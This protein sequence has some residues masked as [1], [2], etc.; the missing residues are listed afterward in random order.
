[1]AKKIFQS[2][3]TKMR[4][5]NFSPEQK[6]KISSSD[7]AVPTD[8]QSKYQK[9]I[10]THAGVSLTTGS[11]SSQGN[12]TNFVDCDGFNDISL[13]LMNDAA[14]GNSADIQWSNDGVNIHGY[15]YGVIPSGTTQ[16]KA[17]S[18]SV[19]ARY[20]KVRINN[21][22]TATHVMSAWAFLKA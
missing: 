21:T 18:T 22:D 11:S 20:F 7:I 9:T 14:T 6:V 5:I 10:Q 19:K 3:S 17:G 2:I 1:M 4:G 8:Q 13:T 16:Y 15:D 12:L